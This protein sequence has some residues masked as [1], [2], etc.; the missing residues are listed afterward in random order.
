[1]PM[2]P[3][4]GAAET[5]PAPRPLPDPQDRFGPH[6][7]RPFANLMEAAKDEQRLP[8]KALSPA[9]EDQRPQAVSANKAT[10]LL[11]GGRSNS[12]EPLT[13]KPE[14]THPQNK[15]LA[16]PDGLTMMLKGAEFLP[17]KGPGEADP[18]SAQIAADP[19][20]APLISGQSPVLTPDA[21][22]VVAEPSDAA[23]IIDVP[24]PDA[25][26]QLL[27]TDPA[28]GPVM[29]ALSL[30]PAPSSQGAGQSVLINRAAT[31]TPMQPMPFHQRAAAL[32]I[33]PASAE[34]PRLSLSS[35]NMIAPAAANAT[36]SAVIG[37]SAP[38]P[39]AKGN[40]GAA[41][42]TPA[43]DMPPS[44]PLP[45]SPKSLSAG[46]A[47]S[48][49]TPVGMGEAVSSLATFGT[50]GAFAQG[51]ASGGLA[52]ASLAASPA[53]A[54][55]IIAQLNG[56]ARHSLLQGQSHLRISLHPSELGQVDVRLTLRDGK[57]TAHLVVDRAETLEILQNQSRHLEKALADQVARSDDRSESKLELSLKNDRENE[58]G[59][60]RSGQFG[61]F[62]GGSSGDHH[63]R[64]NRPA[65]GALA[66]LEPTDPETTV[67]DKRAAPLLWGRR[68]G[69]VDVTL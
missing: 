64:S 62:L 36:P 66:G 2:P 29:A 28:P 48:A 67:D 9:L 45:S 14:G 32:S 52:A 60:D 41:A 63:D 17:A 4:F 18:V 34:A 39:P 37:Q 16:A 25:P 30:A 51:A 35:Q 54:N 12:D 23:P 20:I 69:H 59:H 13:A 47:L 56:S 68:D 11:N 3:G 55:Q 26:A 46:M 31:A 42:P 8:K 40:T 21:T 33:L 19:L 5:R 53:I 7:E 44:P 43:L 49:L 22:I 27:A 61:G 50:G 6:D 57:M 38:P 65:F 10:V 58:R 15:H 1:M 24:S